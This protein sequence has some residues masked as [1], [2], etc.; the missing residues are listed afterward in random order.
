MS[1]FLQY[2]QTRRAAVLDARSSEG[3]TFTKDGLLG[4]LRSAGEE[5]E[6]QDGDYLQRVENRITGEL[7]TYHAHAT[8]DGIWLLDTQP[9][10]TAGQLFYIERTFDNDGRVQ[11]E[12]V[13]YESA[14]CHHVVTASAAYTYT[15]DVVTA[16]RFTGGYEGYRVEGLPQVHWDAMLS[17]SFDSGSRLT[18][19][20]LAVTSFQKLWTGKPQGTVSDEVRRYYTTLKVRKPTDIRALGDVCAVGGA[21][22]IEEAIDLRPFFIVSPAVAVRLDHG[23]ARVA[24]DYVYSDK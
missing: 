24:V 4:S 19:E 14:A 15:G 2:S 13:T 21:G 17:R 16:A 9:Y 8:T 18:H 11:H 3:W 10:S 12:D 20:D 7:F 22:V 6:L 5:I 1:E 23:D